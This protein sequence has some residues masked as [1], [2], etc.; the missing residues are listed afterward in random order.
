MKGVKAPVGKVRGF[1]A[2]AFVSRMAT[3]V[4]EFAISAQES[5][6]PGPE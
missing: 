2:G 6:S 5:P 1:L 4:G 3:W